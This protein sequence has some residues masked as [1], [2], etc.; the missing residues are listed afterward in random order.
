MSKEFLPEHARLT[1]RLYG[2]S[3]LRK[4]SRPVKIVGPSERMLIGAMIETMHRSKGVGL[5]APQ[6]GVNKEILVVDIG[7][8]PM[9]VV[10][11]QILKKSGSQMMEEGCLSLP[12]VVVNLRRPQ[13]FSLKYW[14]ENNEVLEREYS[15]LL[16][17][18]IL[19]EI[20]HLRGKLIIDYLSLTQRLKIRKTL[21]A[22][23]RSSQTRKDDGGLNPEH[24]F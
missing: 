19:H 11:P 18:V 6:V 14:N 10:N 5:A 2:D 20:D 22:L 3:V 21:L 12:G 4:K 17:R 13:K 23:R 7:P 8:G 9:V 16:A 1:I 15:D 24:L